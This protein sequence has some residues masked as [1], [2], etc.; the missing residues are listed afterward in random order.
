[1]TN[2]KVSFLGLEVSFI[3]ISFLTFLFLTTILLAVASSSNG[4]KL[5]EVEQEIS[6]LEE[7]NRNLKQ[8]IV[9][10][11]SL[12]EVAKKAEELGFVKPEEILY[13][14]GVKKVAQNR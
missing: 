3:F 9:S 2:K 5:V 4:A 8:A 14:A 1:M 12:S 6:R 7:E 10:K 13:L 11:S